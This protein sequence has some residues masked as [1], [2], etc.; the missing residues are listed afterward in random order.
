MSYSSSRSS[1]HFCSLFTSASTFGFLAC[2]TLNNWFFP[3]L[4]LAAL[5]D[6]HHAEWDVLACTTFSEPSNCS[7][8]YVK[9][10]TCTTTIPSP[11]WS[12]IYTSLLACIIAKRVSTHSYAYANPTHLTGL[13]GCPPFPCY[14]CIVTGFFMYELIYFCKTRWCFWKFFCFI[15]HFSRFQ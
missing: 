3:V 14:I 6:L 11:N 15:P 8:V 5:F 10:L 12:H 2:I 13:S 7:Q 9:Y 4:R 1:W